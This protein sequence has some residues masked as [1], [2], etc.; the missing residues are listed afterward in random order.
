MLAGG[1]G[2]SCLHNHGDG[3]LVDCLD[4]E[5]NEEEPRGSDKTCTP[6]YCH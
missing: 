4:V 3:V 2:N 5:S 6:S 1:W